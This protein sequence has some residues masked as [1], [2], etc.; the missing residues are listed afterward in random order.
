[1][2]DLTPLDYEPPAV[3]DLGTLADMTLGAIGDA[4]AFGGVSGSSGS[5]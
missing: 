4:D 5:L 3:S 2:N 1:M